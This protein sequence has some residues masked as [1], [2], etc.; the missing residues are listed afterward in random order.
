[1]LQWRQKRL[2]TCARARA[3]VWARARERVWV[4]TW[5]WSRED[6]GEGVGKGK[7]VGEG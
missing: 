2:W 6:V 7:A 4:R 5:V 3:R 1:M